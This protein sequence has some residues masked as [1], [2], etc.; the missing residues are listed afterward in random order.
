MLSIGMGNR[1]FRKTW[2]LVQD[3]GTVGTDQSRL[4][5]R[6]IEAGGSCFDSLTGLLATGTLAML[7]GYV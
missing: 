3:V 2:R 1:V 4:M 7:E 6:W 5:L